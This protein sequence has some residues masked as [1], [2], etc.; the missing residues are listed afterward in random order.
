MLEFIYNIVLM[1]LILICESVFLVS[2]NLIKKYFVSFNDYTFI[3]ILIVSLTINILSLPLYVAAENL[4]VEE[5]NKQKQMNKVI[6][7][8][9][10]T[11]KG[12]ERF[13][14]LNSYYKLEGYNPILQL[15]LAIPLFL[16]IPFFSAAYSFFT[17]SNLFNGVPLHFLP[18]INDLSKPDMMLNARG[19]TI[20]ILPIFMT[21]IN[22]VSACIYTSG[23]NYRNRI[24]PILLAVVFLLLLYNS[25][26]ALVIYWTF[27]NLF[28][29]IKIVALK[30]KERSYKT[31]LSTIVLNNNYSKLPI[32]NKGLAIISLFTIFLI[33]GV[34]IPSN[35]ISSSPGE[36]VIS[37]PYNIL[38]FTIYVFFGYFLWGLLYVNM[39]PVK[40]NKV[41]GALFFAVCIYFIL[42]HFAFLNKNGTLT[43]S[44]VYSSG[45]KRYTVRDI[46]FDIIFI[47]ISLFVFILSIKYNNLALKISLILALSVLMVSLS[48]I[49]NIMIF[50][51]DYGNDHTF[52]NNINNNYGKI[53]LSS[54]D[55]G[56]KNVIV[57]MLDR[58]S[59]IYFDYV[60]GCK[61]EL[62]NTFNGFKF[63]PNTVS[64]SDITLIGSQPLFGGY[65]YLPQNSNKRKDVLLVDKHNEALSIMPYNFSKSGYNCTVANLP[66]ENY[67]IKSRTPLFSNIKNVS[68]ID[69]IRD[70]R[71]NSFDNDKTLNAY[72]IN[73]KFIFFSIMKIA[74]IAT[75][76]IIY[77][78]LIFS[79]DQA[80]LTHSLNNYYAFDNLIKNIKIVNDNSFNFFMYD[81]EL[82][83]NDNLVVLPSEIVSVDYDNVKNLKG[84]IFNGNIFHFSSEVAAYLQVGKFIDYL[85]F[86]NVYDNTRIIIVSDH[87]LNK[88][89]GEK[90]NEQYIFKSCNRNVSYYN[91]TLLFK[92]FESHGELQICNDFMVNAD[93][94]FMAMHGLVKEPIN[95]YINS[96]IHSRDGNL[97]AID[98]FEGDKGYNPSAYIND[99]SFDGYI[100]SCQTNNIFNS[101]CWFIKSEDNN[102]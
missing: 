47:L 14:V 44:L 73:K 36:F 52:E 86:N 75:K 101:N 67:G 41:L 32:F 5:R 51:K 50:T 6:S 61:P 37:T 78:N 71:S 23:L 92:D 10:N 63:Y 72:N 27:N 24:Q 40:L 81:N 90:L 21:V 33:L 55:S 15:R 31:Q 20:N 95:P 70:V 88:D 4:Q 54:A 69:L 43:E 102:E 25:P 76:G 45:F 83:H 66:Y 65:D 84:E 94:P 18:I 85:K 49:F 68:Q 35:V 99:T 59:G 9:N 3:G 93:V 87:G 22:L 2:C 57:I 100:C 34:F 89:L 26:S 82:T 53:K 64:C 62:I 98:I 58:S 77:S 16:Q 46:Y 42:N 12:D 30:L 28:S 7:H 19:I 29:L 96:R 79:I 11:F 60:M 39:L 13:L 97:K 1:P 80:R 8:I 17:N 74:P 56:G 48:N 38:K 91:P